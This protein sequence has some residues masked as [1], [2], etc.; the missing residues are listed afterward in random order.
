MYPVTNDYLTAIRKPVVQHSIQGTIGSESFN[1]Y[2]IVDGTFEVSRQICDTSKIQ[3]GGVF[4]GSLHCTFVSDSFAGLIPR[5]S[6][7]GKRITFK[8]GTYL[9]PGIGTEWVPG[10]VFTIAEATHTLQGI[11]IVAYDDMTKFDR[12]YNGRVFGGTTSAVLG[13]LCSYLGVAVDYS[14]SNTRLDSFGLVELSPDNNFDT[15][16]DYLSA[17]L[18]SRC[19]YSYIDRN[20]K[21]V[22]RSCLD[23]IADRAGAYGGDIFRIP[24]NNRFDNIAVSDY[25]VLIYGASYTRSETGAVE[26]LGGQSDNWTFYDFGVNPFLQDSYGYQRFS[27]LYNNLIVLLDVI[28]YSVTTNS[29]IALEFGDFVYLP[30]GLGGYVTSPIMGLNYVYKHSVTYEGYGENPAK[31]ASSTTGGSSG[32]GS[33]IAASKIAFYYKESQSSFDIE[34][35]D[36]Q[37]VNSIEFLADQDCEANIWTEIK[38]TISK[39]DPD[40][41]VTVRVIYDYDDDRI[42]YSPEFTFDENGY[43]TISL[44]YFL[45]YVDSSIS[46]IWDVSLEVT[47]GSFQIANHEVHNLIWGQ[48]LTKVEKWSGRIRVSD[49]LAL[50]LLKYQPE[51]LKAFTDSPNVT[52]DTPL[53]VLAADLTDKERYRAYTFGIFADFCIITIGEA[54]A[55]NIFFTGEDYAGDP[56]STGL[57]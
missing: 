54:D 8:V 4:V 51:T 2:D 1:D 7:V 12:K 38:G 28:P 31:S 24:K 53:D 33:S 42:G 22:F 3:F 47:G 50:Y 17:L 15:W 26:T 5:G 44:N 23:W 32:G 49:E 40:T 55:N 11:E 16:R 29:E 30:D 34:T 10:G 27:Y 45:D 21:F 14:K 57:I 18:E 56:I 6:W 48:G 9:G 39:D 43:Q 35:S 41:P 20:G 46:H 36:I 13:D 52:T 19:L 37:L 25:Q